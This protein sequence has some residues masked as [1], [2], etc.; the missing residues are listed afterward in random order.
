MKRIKVVYTVVDWV[1]VD[2]EDIARE[3]SFER[4]LNEMECVEVETYLE[5]E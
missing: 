1:N 5:E 4:D 2:D 3:I